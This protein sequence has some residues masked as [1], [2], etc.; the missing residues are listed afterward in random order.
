[1]GT[2]LEKLAEFARK[3]AF[4]ARRE[5]LSDCWGSVA[6]ENKQASGFDPVTDCDRNAEQAIRRLIEERFPDHGI[7][8]EEFGDRPA[9]GPL[10][11]SLDPI[12][13][14]RA[15]ICGLPT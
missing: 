12:D 4:T 2:D 1:M 13:G 15:Y 6:V 5:T 11:W 7:K 9:R 3:L 10:S 8:G 14:T